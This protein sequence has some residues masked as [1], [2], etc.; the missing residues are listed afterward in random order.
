MYYNTPSIGAD[1]TIYIVNYNSV[2]YKWRSPYL[3]YVDIGVDNSSIYA[4][5]DNGTSGSQKWTYKME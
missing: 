3:K 1:G 2:S 4:I 5:T